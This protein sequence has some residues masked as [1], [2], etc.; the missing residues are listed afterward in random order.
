VQA[1]NG[2]N[3]SQKGTV[4]NSNEDSRG[5]DVLKVT[6]RHSK[7]DSRRPLSNAKLQQLQG[8]TS[9]IRHVKG[10]IHSGT[11][12]PLVFSS[13][14]QQQ[15]QQQRR[16]VN[17]R[18]YS[19]DSHSNGSSDDGLDDMNSKLMQEIQK[20]QRQLL[21]QEDEMSK[22]RTSVRDMMKAEIQAIQAAEERK[23][24]EERLQREQ[25]D[26]QDRMIQAKAEILMQQ[27]EEKRKAEEASEKQK[28]EIADLKRQ[29]AILED[30]E[31]QRKE[32]EL[33]LLRY[34][35]ERYRRQQDRF[36]GFV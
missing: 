9:A 13:Q 33:E 3:Q 18:S 21:Q 19:A 12:T 7:A 24:E 1:D 34:E 35:N 27:R 25:A 16:G 14:Q 22:E 20:L 26:I 23:R 11:V 6:A 30:A 32:Q 15:Q 17:S 10:L 28:Q 4:L 5:D 8:K 31:R 2:K 36:S 29:K